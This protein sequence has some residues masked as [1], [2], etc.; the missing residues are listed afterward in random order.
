L[1]RPFEDLAG[2]SK[3][4]PNWVVMVSHKARPFTVGRI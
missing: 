4:R 2:P 1:G 3:M